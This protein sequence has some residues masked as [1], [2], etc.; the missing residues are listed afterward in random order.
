MVVKPVDAQS[1]RG[2]RIVQEELALPAA[3]AHARAHSRSGRVLLDPWIPGVE[4]IAD[5]FVWQGRITLLGLCRKTADPANPTVAAELNYLAGADFCAL[6]EQVEPVLRTWLELIE[7]RQ[8]ICHLEFIANGAGLWPIDCAARGGGA[9]TY[10][11]VLPAVSGVDAVAA[12][13]QA[14]LGRTPDLRTGARQAACVAFARTDAGWLRAVQ[15]L[16]RLPTL[17]GVLGWHVAAQ[18][19]D[20]LGVAVDKDAR[21]AWVVAGAPD[22]ELARERA[23]AALRALSWEI[24][25]EPPHRPQHPGQ[26]PVSQG[27]R[28]AV[29]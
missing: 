7:L 28:D 21:P 4:H 15:G 6:A 12:S 27:E 3:L 2:V 18:A 9:M 29:L 8:G 14:A 20:R 10:T 11:H 13:I 22:S 17:P 5:V 16:E 19:G 25:S 26:P 23:Q 1:G 24:Q